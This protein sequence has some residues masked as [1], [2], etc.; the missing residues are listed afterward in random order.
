M[1]NEITIQQAAETRF[2]QSTTSELQRY[3]TELGE[4]FESNDDQNKLRAKVLAAMGLV[5][6]AG[7]QERKAPSR[8]TFA[9][10]HIRP[11][12][13]LSPNGLWGGRRRRIRVPRPQGSKL[14]RAECVS[15]NGKA[16]YW[17]AYDETTDVPFPIYMALVDRKRKI[18]S[19]EKVDKS[20]PNS[21][22][23]TKWEFTDMPIIDY[24][25]DPLTADRAGSITEWYQTNAPS[26]FKR[27]TT[28][29]LQSICSLLEITVTKGDV[30]K[31]SKSD[32][33]LISD[34]YV[35]LWGHA[36]VVD[37]VAEKEAEA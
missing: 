35:F 27:R 37:A 7:Q 16:P 12:Y 8:A 1:S 32:E 15:V 22:I 6:P 13:N 26:W 18:V 31:T 24:G 34:I 23:T 33:E 2:A 19:A 5:D 17:I 29:E 3:L 28:R 30:M 25:D 36:A 9:G 21:E 11:P 10:E 4:P 14:A 20:D